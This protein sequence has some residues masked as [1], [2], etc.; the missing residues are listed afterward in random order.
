MEL[1][2]K[3]IYENKEILVLDKPSGLVVHANGRNS[4]PT[5]TDWLLQN[6]PEIQGVGEPLFIRK[7]KEEISFDRS[8]IVH[9]LDRDTSGAMAVAKTKEAYVFL[10]EQFE[11]RKVQKTYLAFV[12]GNI[13][14]DKGFVDAPIGKSRNDFRQWQAGDN[15]RG[16]MRDAHTDFSVIKRVE[17]N[18]E[19]FCL[20]EIQPKTGRTHQIRVH[21]KYI[22]HPVVGDHLYASSRPMAFGFDRLAL[23]AWKLKIIMLSGEE[24]EF[25]AKMPE[26]FEKLVK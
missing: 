9:R 25:E 1:I 13:K 4:E 6:Y 14:E 3:I 7:G 16:T 23:H 2:P 21:M 22:H 20:C 15:A 8:G 17:E 10:K 5:L 12:W 11:T 26:M 18:G 19:H 24:K